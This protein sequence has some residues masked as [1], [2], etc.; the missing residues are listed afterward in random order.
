[1]TTCL[2]CPSGTVP[3]NDVSGATTKCAPCGAGTYRTAVD[4]R[5][6]HWWCCRCSCWHVR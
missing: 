6:A 3:L 1:M 4:I 2:P 5:C